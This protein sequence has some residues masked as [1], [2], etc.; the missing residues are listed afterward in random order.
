MV[1]FTIVI[2]SCSSLGKT[3]QNEA[4]S[5]ALESTAESVLTLPEGWNYETEITHEGS[6]SEGSISRLF[7]RYNEILPVFDK[8]IIGDI[9]FEYKPIV[10][11]WDN[12][13]YLQTGKTSDR[14]E[15]SGSVS[16]SELESGWYLSHEADIKT[17]TP[18]DWV[19]IADEVVEARISPEK[20]NDFAVIFALKPETTAPILLPTDN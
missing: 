2:F 6:R 16:K 18:S 19:W 17:G 10:N 13:G 9:V 4:D 11:I 8:I 7:Y 14:P 20:I 1:F 15:S 5:D 12:T 3:E